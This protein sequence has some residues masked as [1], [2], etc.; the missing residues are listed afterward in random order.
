MVRRADL[1]L[2]L[3]S[4][5]PPPIGYPY[6]PP[7]PIDLLTQISAN[8]VVANTAERANLVGGA[9]AVPGQKIQ[10]LFADRT[11]R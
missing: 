8:I 6:P 1:A 9:V 7:L 11:Q 4:Q 2:F 10:L 3:A 5:P